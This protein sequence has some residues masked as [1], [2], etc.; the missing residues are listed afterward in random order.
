MTDPISDKSLK[1][2]IHRIAH[3]QDGVALYLYLQRKLMT[4][5]GADNDSALNKMEGQRT[6]ALEL[7]NLMTKGITE[8]GGRTSS[9]G[10][11]AEQPLVFAAPEPVD[12]RRSRGAGR[13]ITEH[14]RVPGWDTPDTGS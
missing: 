3:T 4:V 8:S 7:I 5:T 9:S 13:R 1:E 6:F 11:S 14:T 10:P 2:A 12:T